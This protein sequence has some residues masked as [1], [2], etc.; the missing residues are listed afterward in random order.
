MNDNNG[1]AIVF[2]LIMVTVLFTSAGRSGSMCTENGINANVIYVPLLVRQ[3]LHTEN[4]NDAN[5]VY[6]LLL[7]GQVL[8]TDKGYSVIYLC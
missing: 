6:I 1:T 4:G 7:V 8:H 3:V 5:V 2:V